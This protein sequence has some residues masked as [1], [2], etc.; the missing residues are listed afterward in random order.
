MN[1]VIAM[2]RKGESSKA[3]KL[4]K[5]IVFGVVSRG[6]TAD[7]GMAGS[8]LYHMAMITK[9]E[10][11]TRL[12]LKELNMDSPDTTVNLKRFFNDFS[13]DAAHLINL[14]CTTS[15]I[16]FATKNA[17]T[18]SEKIT[19]FANLDKKTRHVADLINN[20]KTQAS[21]EVETLF[22]EWSTKVA[23]MRFLQ[24]YQTMKG[25][26]TLSE[27]SRLV[28]LKR[29]GLA[30]QEV[31]EKFGQETVNI[32][33]DVTLKVGLRR[34]KLQSIMLS[35]HYIDYTMSMETLDGHMKFLNCPIFG[36]HDYISKQLGVDT[37]EAL[38]FCK[39]FCFS[40]A[41]AM[42]ETVL[43]FTFELTQ[44]QVMKTHGE[45]D[46]YLRL[47]YSPYATTSARFIPLVVSWNLTRKCNLKCSHC[48]INAT[49]K[50][51]EGELNTEESKKLI[52]QIAEVSRPLLILSGGEPLLRKDVFDLVRY[53]T[54]KGLR[55]GLGSNGGLIDKDVA[56]ELRN[57]GI[58]TVSISID[59]NIAAQHDD[60]RGVAGSWDKAINAIKVLRENDVLVQVNTTV[61]Q[62]NYKQIDDIM[63]LTEQIGVENFHL[64]FLV[65]TGRGAKMA[66]IS[67]AMYETMIKGAFSKV[68]KHQLNVRPSCAPQF[69]R[70]A[71]DIGLDMRQWIRGC[72]AGLYYCRVYP[73]GDITPCPYLPVR[74]GNVRET[75]F[76][77]IW[78][79][80]T[81]FNALRNPGLLK[82][83]CGACNYRDICGGCR[84]RAYGLSSDFIDFCGDLHE[85]AEL[86]GDYLAEDPWCVYNP[87]M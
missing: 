13:K 7:P 54:G 77:E 29:I 75:S 34:E 65:P 4:F 49:S 18:S 66:D 32:A 24:E 85:P 37:Q 27:L 76:K 46:F 30:M 68:G 55:M 38:L 36:A 74:L 14:P 20:R 1:E 26:L 2:I 12:L 50:D 44:P 25:L 59:S 47:G 31:Q 64:F 51:L 78:F 40:H 87:K 41:K 58:K 70:I 5:E 22:N 72:I 57:S 62:Q 15:S 63:S 69:M 81:V 53:G 3:S 28:G 83:K 45:C 84:A 33:L 86:K 43:P 71:K 16:E 42:L 10:T 52:D 61:T 73:N 21:A 56:R 39:Y 9:M 82:G 67:P 35:D 23:D 60:F 79:K 11:E 48:Y 8:L 19:L 6:E 17:L 80:S